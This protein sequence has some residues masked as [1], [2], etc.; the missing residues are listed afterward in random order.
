MLGAAQAKWFA[1]TLARSTARWKIV[2]CDQ[3]LALAIADGPNDSRFEGFGNAPGPPIG[4]EVELAC[5]LAELATRSVRDVVW[6]TADVHYAAAHHF[7][8]V[9]GAGTKFEPFWE[10][11]AGPI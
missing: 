1:D 2:A 7:D 10:F 4:R 11:V 8:P 9:R 6:V 3:P 5:V